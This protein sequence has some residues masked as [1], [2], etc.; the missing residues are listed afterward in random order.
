MLDGPKTGLILLPD[1]PAPASFV[2]ESLKPFFV[3]IGA[4]PY[5]VI[6]D[7]FN[8]RGCSEYFSVF[9]LPSSSRRGCAE[10]AAKASLTR[11]VVHSSKPV[12]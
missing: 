6:H 4:I 7:Q 12:G 3:C 11:C 5:D 2:V 1:A 10:G 8:V 9:H